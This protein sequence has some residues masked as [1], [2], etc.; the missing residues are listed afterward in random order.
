MIRCL[1]QREMMHEK[2]FIYNP[3]L[4]PLAAT[5]IEAEAY[6]NYAGLQGHLPHGKCA[7]NVGAR[8]R[9]T[10]GNRT[11]DHFRGI[12]IQYIAARIPRFARA[13][14][15]IPPMIVLKHGELR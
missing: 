3:F 6:K 5:V 2:G 12:D 14:P 8:A 4:R 1:V 10:R 13:G 7:S 15:P 11:H 9:V